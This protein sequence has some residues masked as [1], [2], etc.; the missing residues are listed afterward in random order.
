VRKLA[1]DNRERNKVPRELISSHLAR[2]IVTRSSV[3]QPKGLRQVEA[4]VGGEER[5]LITSLIF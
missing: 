2:T 3:T 5:S 1:V 4:T